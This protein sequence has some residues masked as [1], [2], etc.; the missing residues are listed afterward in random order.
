MDGKYV[1]IGKKAELV[2]GLFIF[3]LGL[4]CAIYG[5]K[6]G[7]GQL[8]D[9]GPGAFPLGLGV[10]LMILSVL[11]M[12]EAGHEWPL[13]R[14]LSPLAI[15]LPAIVIWALLIESAG[16]L[17]ATLALIVVCSFVDDKLSVFKAI[18]LGLV[19]AAVGY[20]VFILGFGL[21]FTL[22]GRML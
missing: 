1:T 22:T 9:I 3:A 6:Y 16:L 10:A 17:L 4:I 14:K 13:S 19:L 7:P 15:Y 12:A 20:V 5:W 11:C 2:F 18:I 21:P 8:N